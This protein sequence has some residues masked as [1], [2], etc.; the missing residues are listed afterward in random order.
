M[1]LCL[2]A[3]T[4]I[5]WAQETSPSPAPSSEET[6]AAPAELPRQVPPRPGETGQIPTTTGLS[7]TIVKMGTGE[8]VKTGETVR[9]HY[10]GWLMDGTKFDSSV[11][12]G[13]PFEVQIGVG[14]VIKGWDQAIVGMKTGE[15]RRLYIPANLAYGERGVGPIPPNATLVFEVELISHR[16]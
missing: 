9:A 15:V 7:F 5:L 14:R 10:T 3:M 16:P 13:E 6:P 8:S 12:R 2:V 1:L 11:D 4:A